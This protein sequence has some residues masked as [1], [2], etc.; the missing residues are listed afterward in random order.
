MDR[1]PWPRGVNAIEEREM[2]LCA[3]QHLASA[4][5]RMRA[6]WHREV[7][8]PKRNDKTISWNSSC[9]HAECGLAPYREVTP[10]RCLGAYRWRGGPDPRKKRETGR[11]GGTPSERRLLDS[12]NSVC[13]IFQMLSI[14]SRL[15]V[16][17][18]SHWTS[19]ESC[20]RVALGL[21]RGVWCAQVV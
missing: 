10:R 6:R 18:S 17:R 12:G 5:H 14:R 21:A 19:S 15:R 2:H 3:L 8:P 7:R 20:S 16:H 4:Q 13:G 9:L 11:R 1:H